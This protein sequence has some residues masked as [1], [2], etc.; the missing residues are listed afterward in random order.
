[1]RL[2]L[3][4]A[5]LPVLVLV[6]CKRDRVSDAGVAASTELRFLITGAENGYL[7]ATRDGPNLRGGAAEVLGRWVEKEGHC[8]GALGPEGESACPG[9]NT[10]ALSTGDNANGSALSAYFKGEPTAEVMRLMGYAASAFG[11][12]ELD[13]D[14]ERFLS[15]T[16]R[17]GFPYLAANVIVTGPEGRAL[18]LR[19]YRLL[20]RRGVK[21][22]VVG[23]AARKASWTAM[24][25]RMKGLEV[26]P[27]DV[28]LDVAIPAARAEGAT[29]VV[30]VT[31]GC[32]DDW[33]AMLAAHPAWGP[34]FVAGRDCDA[35]YPEAVGATRLVYPGRHLQGYAAVAVTV[36]AG[37]VSAVTPSWVDVV[38]TP[39]GP[40]AEPKTVAV[41]AEWQQKLAPLLGEVIGYSKA[42]VAQ[43]SAEMS[44]WLTT[45]LRDTFKTDAALLNRRGVR[46]GL[47]PGAITRATVWDLIPFDNQ[48]LVVKVRGD[49]LLA[50]LKNIEARSTG[51]TADGEQLVDGKGKPLA[52][53]KTYTVATVDYLYLGGDGF[54]L[55]EDDREPVQTKLSWQQTLADWTAAQKTNETTPLETLLAK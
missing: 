37:A 39:K 35:D 12:H 49:H 8:V 52:K 41:L 32:L 31:D 43:D 34:A 18:G 40:G 47:P 46:Q 50:A 21:V 44:R 17:G 24:P 27:D 28:A 1:M 5:L 42:G 11:N 30:V 2:R 16:L 38:T 45:A 54:K 33:P 23:L 36:R 13:W 51:I 15:N 10:I 6:G 53:D 55:M 7:T 22:A 48:V 29:V 19:P 3:A 20:T 26:V 25:G 4:V 9:G 14:R